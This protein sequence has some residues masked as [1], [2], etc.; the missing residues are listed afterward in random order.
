M[1]NK[2]FDDRSTN[3]DDEYKYYLWR[4]EK[5]VVFCQRFPNSIDFSSKNILDLG[6]GHGALSI[7]AI[8]NGASN[9]IGID[10]NK[11]VIEFGNKLL[12]TK[13]NNYKSRVKFIT[14]DISELGNYKFDLIIS[15][16]SF[17][18]IIDPYSVLKRIETLLEK[19]GKV[20]IASV[21][22]IKIPFVEVYE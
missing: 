7:Y 9:V 1:G 22:E 6:C 20:Y 19:N 14:A 5:A 18:H 13:F 11:T 16:A 12:E 2:I 10:V 17:E 4:K 3:F 15:Q 8:E 21:K